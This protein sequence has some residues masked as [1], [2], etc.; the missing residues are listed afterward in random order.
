METTMDKQIDEQMKM[1]I[2]A[3]AGPITR[4]GVWRAAEGE[5]A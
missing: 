3:Y 1:A 2:E 4:C 5:V